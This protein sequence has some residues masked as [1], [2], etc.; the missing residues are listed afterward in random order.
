MVAGEEK[1]AN[2]LIATLGI[3]AFYHDSAA[4][5]IVD[6]E[7]ISAAQEERFSRIK[8]DPAFPISA[9]HYCLEEGRINVSQLGS[10]VY[11]DQPSKIFERLV[12]SYAQAAPK[13]IRSWLKDIPDWIA[14]KSRIQELIQR[15]LQY[16]GVVL[17][18][19]HHL[20]HAASAFYPSPYEK[21]AILTVDA[22]GEWATASYGVGEGENIFLQKE[23]R[24]P[25]SLGLLYSAFTHFCGFRIN[26]GEYKLM[27]L[28]PYGQPIFLD[29]IKHE[30]GNI[31]ED[32]S[33]Q[34]NPAYLNF[35]GKQEIVS[36][37]FE[38]LFGPRRLPESRITHR[39][40]DLAASIQVF[41][42]EVILKMA[43]W[44][45][46]ETKEKYLCMAG[47][48]ALNCVANGRLLRENIF[49]DIWIQPAAGDA[50]GAL[51]AAFIAQFG[52]HGVKRP[53]IRTYLDH[54]RGSFLGPSFSEQ[55]I[56]SFIEVEGI[57]ATRLEIHER[58]SKVANA[59]ANGAIV[60]LFSGRMEFGPRALGSRSIIGDARRNDMQQRMN[61]K[62][63][64]R[65]SFRPFA[66]SVLV[67][68]IADYFE[69]DRPSPY[70]LFTAQ[71]KKSRCEFRDN[72][73]ISPEDLLEAVNQVRSDVPAITHWNYS[74]RLQTVHHETNNFFYAIL[75]EFKKITGCS[76]V[77]NTSFNVRGEPIVC[78][79]RDAF[80][81]FMSTDIDYLYLEGYWL[82]KRV[83]KSS[84]N[85]S[86]DPD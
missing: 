11:Y 33:I 38:T 84:L 69:F 42:E 63:K 55:E 37:K 64:F 36:N 71:V 12:A 19:P 40:M 8:G 22:V 65:E 45:K 47:G 68:D 56:K 29:K 54:Q 18:T 1:V 43:R 31:S 82:D 3:S 86:Y 17:F 25:D 35:L 14:K 81:C 23:M 66:P 73:K 5:L 80:N 26:S 27:G 20:A 79:P 75:Q 41:T 48:V 50:G 39:E 77:V 21:A 57:S 76:L 28:A 61:M 85:T 24:F 72:T 52:Y 13:G 34:L 32:G 9:I 15:E 2:N 78:T 4:A 59:I 62:I 30:I 49:E 44:I 46:R 74:A 60:G 53:I 6:G 58:T 7:I 51:G 10:I 67:D 70:M 16:D 83:Q